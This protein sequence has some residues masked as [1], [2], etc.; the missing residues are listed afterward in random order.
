[1]PRGTGAASGRVPRPPAAPRAPALAPPTAPTAGG[2]ITPSGPAPAR[3]AP[4][5]PRAA[6]DEICPCQPR[7][8]AAAPP[9]RSPPRC[10]AAIAASR[11]VDCSLTLSSSAVD[12]TTPFGR[13]RTAATPALSGAK[14]AS[15]HVGNNVI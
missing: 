14:G 9:G 10:H 1:T 4:A 15:G 2:Q 11:G 6:I 5:S 12:G 13:I 7:S 3:S 8:A